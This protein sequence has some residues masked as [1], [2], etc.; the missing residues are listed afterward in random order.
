MQMLEWAETGISNLA[1]E[2]AMVFGLAMWVTTFPRIRRKFFELFFYTHYL[3]IP[4]M[5]FYVFHVGFSYFCITFPGF[6]LF[7][8]D[9]YLRFLQ[10]QRKV[11]LVSARILPC[12]AVELNFSKCLGLRYNPTSIM[13]ISLPGISKLQWH[14]FTVTSNNNTDPDRHD[15]LVMISG[16]SGITPFFSIIRELLFYASTRSCKTKQVLLITS[17]K[18][19]VDLTMLDLLLPVSANY[20]ITQLPLRIEA[21]V[22]REK[23]PI[24]DDQKLCQTVWFLPSATDA[25]VS[26]SLGSNTWL[27]HGAI[28]SSSFFTFLLFFGILATFYVYPVDNS[29]STRFSYTGKNALSMFFVCLS[30]AMTATAA[31]IWHEKQNAKKMMQIHSLDRPKPKGIPRPGQWLYNSKRDLESFPHQSLFQNTTVHYGERPDFKIAT[32]IG[33][34]VAYF[35]VPMR[36]LGQDSWK[37]AAAL[38][39]RHIGGAVNYVAIAGALGVSPSVLAAG[40][41]ADNVICAVYFTTLFALASKIPPE[42]STSTKDDGSNMELETSNKLPVLQ[43]AT[44]IAVALIICKLGTSF[45][46]YLGIQGGSLPAITAI[47][48]F[49]VVGASGNIWNVIY[50]APSIFMFAL[51]QIAVHLAVI[52]G[53][54]KL[55][56]FDLKLLL[57]ASNANVGGPTTACGMA[58]AEGWTSLVVP[59]IL[60]GIFGIAIATF[61]GIGFGVTVLKT[62]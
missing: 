8:V 51:V 10:S 54:G 21:Y 32:T 11:R 37:I 58:T 14:P 48:F 57:L 18:K 45:T 5:V 39:G 36:S 6:Y 25:P 34:V 44:A 38:M 7:L 42:P 12:K 41:A 56:R 15:T 24:P 60:A 49:T 61:L 4:L 27:W 33:T 59:G 50:T 35:L 19:S 40:L 28:I 1:G 22:T 13:F 47:V 31:F 43:T 17:F 26:A 55:F 20:D 30:I 23:E 46:K 16:G 62:M 2:I 29:T 53:L 52:L 9:R 3:Y